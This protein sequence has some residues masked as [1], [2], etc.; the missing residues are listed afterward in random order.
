MTDIIMDD[1]NN[2]GNKSLLAVA[3]GALVAVATTANCAI[4]TV[5]SIFTEGDKSKEKNKEYTYCFTNILI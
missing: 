3:K 1:E 5:F 4:V 2:S